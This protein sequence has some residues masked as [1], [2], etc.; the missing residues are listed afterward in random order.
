M[1]YRNKEICG[2]F[3]IAF[4]QIRGYAYEEKG[5][6][7]GSFVIF[8]KSCVIAAE[9]FHRNNTHT[10]M[11]NQLTK[12]SLARSTTCNSVVFMLHCDNCCLLVA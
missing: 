4:E 11:F 1:S 2:Q 8:H 9:L 12:K 10:C 6:Y 5:R 3:Y 7:D